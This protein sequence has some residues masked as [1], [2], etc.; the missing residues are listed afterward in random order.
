MKK[1]EMRYEERALKA[2]NEAAKELLN[3]MSRKETNLC[4]LNTERD[5][6]K[7]IEFTDE[8][9][10]EFA[11]L[12]TKT[13]MLKGFS[14]KIVN[15]IKRLSRKHNFMIFENSEFNSL[16]EIKRK[17]FNI[18]EWSDF[19]STYPIEI[20]EKNIFK[21]EKG[22]ILIANENS[23]KKKIFELARKLSE[24]ISGFLLSGKNPKEIKKFVEMTAEGEIVLTQR[25]RI[26]KGK[27][28]TGEVYGSVEE[29]ILAGADMPVIGRGIR[30]V[31]YS[32][33]AA[34]VY[35]ALAWQKYLKRTKK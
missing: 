2:K 18:I 5:S 10:D 1:V 3:L 32:L 33:S 21:R 11:L 25:L 8:L 9:G 15:E 22:L 13:E 34:R 35:R 31:A 4:F 27:I 19:V 6:E 29:A 14:K 16:D 24:F 20:K 23:K 7:F 12:M 17:Y 28:K 26:S 30:N